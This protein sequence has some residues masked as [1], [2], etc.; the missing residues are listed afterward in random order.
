MYIHIYTYIN[1][2]IYIFPAHP[3]SGVHQAGAALAFTRYCHYQ[4]DIVHG[5]QIGSRGSSYIARWTCNSIAIVR[6]MQVGGGNERMNDSCTK[7]SK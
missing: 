2:Y 1:F 6:A 5:I 4:Y 3:G 7:A